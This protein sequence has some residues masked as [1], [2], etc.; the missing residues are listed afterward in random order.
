MGAWNKCCSECHQLK[1]RT[2]S[3]IPPRPPPQV[4]GGPSPQAGDFVGAHFKVT[5]EE[6]IV[7]LDTRDSGRP[8]AFTQVRALGRE[9]GTP[10]DG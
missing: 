5:D 4:G 8:I 3:E 1:V 2:W 9:T 7:L 6:G 10:I